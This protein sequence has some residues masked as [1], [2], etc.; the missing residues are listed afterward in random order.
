MSEPSANEP[1]VQ[2]IVVEQR[3][4]FARKLFVRLLIA[5]LGCSLFANLVL[6][7]YV[8]LSALMSESQTAGEDVAP[9][10]AS[11]VETYHSGDANAKDKIAVIQATGVLMDDLTRHVINQAKR[12]QSDKRVR[13][14][15]LQI[16]SPGGL[17]ADSEQIYHRLTELRDGTNGRAGKPIVVS[18]TSLAASGGYYI[19]TAAGPEGKFFAEPSCITGSIGVIMPR[20]DVSKLLE[21]YQVQI[22]AITTGPMKDAGSPFRPFDEEERAYWRG[23]L[24]Q[25]YDRFLEVV[26]E[27][28][29]DLAPEQLKAL[30]DGRVY[31]AQ[32][33][34]ENGLIDAVGY[35]EDAVEEAKAR[36]HLTRAR[37][38]T[39]GKE[40]SML[41]RLLGASSPTPAPLS[42]DVRALLELASPRAYYI[43]GPAVPATLR[44]SQ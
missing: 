1:L 30:A 22:E 37:V 21:Q 20:Y 38:V 36:A 11:L 19:A 29:P 32:E 3:D 8:G 44:T 15:V 39:Y 17:V 23:I 43:M 10:P 13:A 2:R 41:G 26:G 4:S 16:D 5:F 31:T 34:L 35:V 40:P 33:A 12:A 27:A 7:A 14:V 18:M 24:N 6:V 9:G 42:L 28:R 25:S